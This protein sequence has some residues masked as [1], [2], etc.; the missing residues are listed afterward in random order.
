MVVDPV[1]LADVLYSTS[2][3]V[4][5]EPPVSETVLPIMLTDV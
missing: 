4:I 1:E 2:H 5:A 3:C